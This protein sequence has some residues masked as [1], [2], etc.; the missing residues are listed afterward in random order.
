[1]SNYENMEFSSLNNIDFQLIISKITDF[2]KKLKIK[3]IKIYTSVFT[4][5]LKYLDKNNILFINISQENISK[6]LDNLTKSQKISF[7]KILTF[8]VKSGHLSKDTFN[9]FNTNVLKVDYYFNEYLIHLK[10]YSKMKNTILKHQNNLKIFFNYCSL[11]EKIYLNSITRDILEEYM[12]EL[13]NTKTIRHNKKLSTSTLIEYILSVKLYFRYL[14]KENHIIYDPAQFLKL[15]KLERKII[16]NYFTQDEIK[17]FFD[18]IELN[19]M[20]QYVMKVLFE[21]MYNLGLRI[22]E[23][24]HLKI[25]DLN[26]E[27]EVVHIREG[28]GGFERS[29]PMS[30]YIKK[31]LKIYI[32]YAYN[33][34]FNNKNGYLFFNPRTNNKISAVYYIDVILKNIVKDL[35]IKKKIS[36]HAFRKSIGKHLLENGLDIRY[37]QKF[38]G[39]KCINA[40][41]SYTILD[42]DDLKEAIEKYH[43]REQ[44][45]D[46]NILKS[47]YTG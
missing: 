16:T 40:T 26:F 11:K 29:V 31:Y 6:Y 1:M 18:K 46:E 27:T 17:M 2:L 47:K 38:L 21:T 45:K 35:E 23:A 28:K 20:S 44:K 7:K 3:N 32:K 22:N 15:P 25:N 43:P 10:K 5:F 13:F 33:N 9:K 41:Q 30:N 4:S 34:Y 8:L 19:K 12:F 36:S 39:H 42:I 14:T 37:V 24:R